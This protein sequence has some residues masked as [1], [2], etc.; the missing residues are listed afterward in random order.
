M[1][2]TWEFNIGQKQ[3]KNPT[4][5]LDPVQVLKQTSLIDQRKKNSVKWL[6]LYFISENKDKSNWKILL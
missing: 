1:R 5:A 4:Q 6:K 3:E 2:F